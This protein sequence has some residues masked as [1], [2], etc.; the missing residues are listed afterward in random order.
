MVDIGVLLELQDLDLDL[1]RFRDE[2]GNIPEQIGEVE[3]ECHRVKE[4]LEAQ[5]AALKALKVT[6][7]EIE[8]KVAQLEELSN[9]YKQHLLTVK[10][11][12][13]YSALLTEIEAAKREKEE[14]ED[15]IL[16]NLEKVESATAG[17]QETKNKLVELE[18]QRQE[19]KIELEGRLK[20]V[21]GEITGLEKKRAELTKRINGNILRQYERI[22][23]SRVSRAVVPLHNGSCGGCFAHVPLQMVANIRIGSQVYN[24]D[25]CGRILY[26]DE[27]HGV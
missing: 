10:T 3:G 27:K 22:M 15:V 19:K 7:R 12:R 1:H 8:G 17:I 13:E 6:I 11:N 18:K 25:Y 24:C 9:R 26:Y 4:E 2:R 21:S 14:L 5:E 16:Q 20:D 23:N